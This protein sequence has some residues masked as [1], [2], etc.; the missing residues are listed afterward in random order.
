MKWACL[1][2]ALLPSWLGAVAA[3]TPRVQNLVHVK[4]ILAE[5]RKAYG[6]GELT[7]ALA[8]ATQA[9]ELEP[10]AVES[11]MFRGRLRESAR[12]FAGAAGDFARVIQLEPDAAEAYVHRG[13]ARFRLG[14]REMAAAD[15]DRAAVLAPARAPQLWQRGLA[16]CEVGS[17]DVECAAWHFLCVAK[18]D[19]LEPARAHLLAVQ[20]DPRVPMAEIWKLFAG[21]G[22]PEDI[23]AAVQAGRPSAFERDVRRFYAGLYLGLFF[24]ATGDLNR[25]RTE[26]ARAVELADKVDYVGDAV[27]LHAARLRETGDK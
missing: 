6:H 17:N 16:L 8:L 27:R 25:A 4:S 9:I 23:E 21:Q 13:Q 14:R 12:D 15:F 7:N 10:R 22:K 19:G 3:E 24:E 11:W 2:L 18:T 5:A 20:G 1:L 26:L